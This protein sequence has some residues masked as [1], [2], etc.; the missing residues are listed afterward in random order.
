MAVAEKTL[1]AMLED[2]VR[3]LV[4]EY[5]QKS[6]MLVTTIDVSWDSIATM[7]SDDVV[8][9]IRSIKIEACHLG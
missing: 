6:G 1:A 9:T 7:G 3:A 4:H 8:S 2:A 5:A